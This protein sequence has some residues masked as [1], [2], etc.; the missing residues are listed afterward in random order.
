MSDHLHH[1]LRGDPNVIQLPVARDPAICAGSC[2]ASSCFGEVQHKTAIF[3]ARPRVGLVFCRFLG[4]D[5][6]GASW[7]AFLAMSEGDLV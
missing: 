7:G 6:A 3:R 2:P 1:G 4:S 5:S